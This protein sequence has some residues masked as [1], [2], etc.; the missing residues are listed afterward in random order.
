LACL[1]LLR[2]ERQ[3]LFWRGVRDGWDLD[4]EVDVRLVL[5]LLEILEGTVGQGDRAD[6][7]CHYRL[8]TALDVLEALVGVPAEESGTV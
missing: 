7:L 4:H 1:W 8:A 3:R 5:T 2:D 6:V